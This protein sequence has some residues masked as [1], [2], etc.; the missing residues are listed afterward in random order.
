[1]DIK[2]IV[3]DLDDTLL[4]TT[5]LLIPIAKTPQFEERITQPLPLMD[6]AKANLDYLKDRYDLA[7]LTQGRPDAQKKKVL[8]LGIE[9]YFKAKYFAD[10]SANETKA[11][12]FQKILDE[13]KLPPASI[14]SIGNRRYTDIREAKKLGMMTCL[15]H[16]GEHADEQVSQKEDI[17][18]FTVINHKELINKCHL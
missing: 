13:H 6:G 11:Q 10:P 17:P 7:L 3:F 14:I 4:D 16:Y 15:F 5:R 18:D 12:Y 1:M 9:N 2:L 8:S